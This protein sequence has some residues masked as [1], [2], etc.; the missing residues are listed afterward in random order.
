ML[1]PHL[2]ILSDAEDKAACPPLV[3]VADTVVVRYLLYNKPCHAIQHRC[4][5]ISSKS[6]RTGMYVFLGFDVEDGHTSKTCPTRGA[7]QVEVKCLNSFVSE[8]TLYP[9]QNIV[10]DSNDITVVTDILS[11]QHLQ[12]RVSSIHPKNH[13]YPSHMR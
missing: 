5:Q 4:I 1:E 8:P 3:E 6:I 12:I 11:N 2:Q 7:E 10:V 13:R 9:T